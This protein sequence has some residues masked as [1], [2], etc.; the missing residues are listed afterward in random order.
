[1]LNRLH[2]I[3]LKAEAWIL[4]TILLSLIVIAVAQVMMRNVIGGGLLWADAYTRIS[5]LWLAMLGAMSGSRQHNH[6]AIDAL[7][8]R[9]PDSWKQILRRI[10]DAL[11]SSICF[12]M[13]WFSIAFVKQEIDYGDTAFADIPTWWCESIIPFG[14]AVIAFRYGVAVF[15]NNEH[16]PVDQ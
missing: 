12:A 10:N 1:M 6:V 8:R 2:R 14:F 11:T 7:V 15:L 9:L 4:V 5:V 3:L 13:A 16:S